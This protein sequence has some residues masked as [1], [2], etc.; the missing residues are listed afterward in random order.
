M[1]LRAGLVLGAH[2]TL[3]AT[4]AARAFTSSRFLR[5]DEAEKAPVAETPAPKGR[6]QATRDDVF[7]TLDTFAGSNFNAQSTMDERNFR[8]IDITKENLLDSV[9]G[10]YG[11]AE[12]VEAD[13]HNVSSF[14]LASDKEILKRKVANTITKYQRFVGDTGSTEVQVAVLS[15]RIA[16]LRECMGKCKKNMVM[17]RALEGHFHKRR[18]LMKYLKRE[19]FDK[20]NLMLVDYKITEEEIWNWGQIPGRKQHLPR[21]RRAYSESRW[22]KEKREKWEAEDAAKAAEAT[23]QTSSFRGQ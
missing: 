8:G 18:R 4:T 17:K 16:W 22:D 15:E 2:R 12:D 3:A 7:V 19:R 14:E 10:S 1:L 6:N 11:L 13:L 21:Y 5:D 20:Y 9:M 23:E